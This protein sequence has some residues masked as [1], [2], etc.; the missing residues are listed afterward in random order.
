MLASFNNNWY[1]AI[2][3]ECVKKVKKR[4]FFRTKIKFLR[5]ALSHE[6]K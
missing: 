2:T 6:Q 5:E 1:N 4:Q 3:I